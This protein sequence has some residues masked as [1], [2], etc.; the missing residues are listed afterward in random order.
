V[1]HLVFPPGPS[2]AEALA[3]VHVASW[4]ETY[5]GLLP[6]AYLARMSV[7]AHARRWL[8]LLTR[9]APQDVTLAADG[10]DGLVGYVSGGPSRRRRPGEAE[11]HTLY[12]LRRAQGSGLGRA[13]LQG[14]ARVLADQG[15]KSLAIS[16][17][18]DNLSARGFYERLGG[19]AEASRPERGPAGGVL[20]EVYYVWPDIT[21][22]T[23]V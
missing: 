13:L 1:E 20:H 15:F 11:V 22:L 19:I 18:R 16:V 10:P 3:K 17:L 6:D 5:V 9:P 21:A 12:V 23:R 14:A 2:D 4:R 8:W 7:E